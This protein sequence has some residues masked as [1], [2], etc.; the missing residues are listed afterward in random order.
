M[1]I[2]NVEIKAKCSDP[3]YVRNILRTRKA[4]FKG[5][6]QQID[7]YFN[8]L[9]GRYKMRE[10]NI[11][12]SLVY[13]DREN[14]AGPKR[15]QVIYYHPRK[16]DLVKEQLSK[17]M[18]ELIVVSKQREIYFINNI[19]F[20][21][22]TVKE[23]G[24]FVEIEAI[25]R[26]GSIGVDKLYEQ[27]REYLNLF[28]INQNDLLTDSYSDML[29]ERIIEVKESSITDI[30]KIASQI[31]EFS[32]PYPEE[33]YRKRLAGKNKLLITATYEGKIAGFKAGYEIDDHFY[34]WLGGV[35]PDFRKKK[36]AQKLL[37]YQEKWCKEKGY[38]KIRIKTRNKH[39]SMLH[40]LL[41]NNYLIIDFKL[42]DNE[43]E[44]RIILEKKL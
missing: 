18:G 8:T 5:T 15:S 16:T 14:I 21:I 39:K 9:N 2:L 32:E 35:L 1:S 38:E 43:L 29:L 33:E 7:T 37:S 31:P 20:H 28:K 22:D 36:I 19:K 4:D 6:D 30:V 44:N 42:R 3:D 26:T 27:C 41:K 13:Y 17:A 24:N 12:F 10:G 23:L 11:E 34:S 40:L 25:D